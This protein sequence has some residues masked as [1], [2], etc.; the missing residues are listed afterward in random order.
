MTSDFTTHLAAAISALDNN[1]DA[2]LLKLLVDAN[3]LIAALEAE[4]KWWPIETA[5]KD[6]THIIAWSPHYKPHVAVVY[7]RQFGPFTR[8][9]KAEG[10]DLYRQVRDGAWVCWDG[11]PVSCWKPTHWMPLPAPPEDGK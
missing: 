10:S 2:S 8:Y 6:G 4:R 9:E 7:G 3:A 11:G 5:P 1:I